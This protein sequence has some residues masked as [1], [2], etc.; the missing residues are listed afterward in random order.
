[1][2]ISMGKTKV[3]LHY[4][5]A[6][7]GM[8]A[9]IIHLPKEKL[10]ASADMYEQNKITNGRWIAASNHL[11][12]RKILNKLVAFK[13]KYAITAHSESLDPKHLITASNFF[14]DLYDAVAP[15]AIKATLG[16]LGAVIKL[17]D[18][19]PKKIK[20]DKYKKLKNYDHLPAHVDRMIFAIFHG[21]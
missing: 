18:T 20:L 9:S 13:P 14:N 10:V 3:D 16:D 6:G 5:G 12:I 1:M 4:Y 21:G 11:G 2:T 17:L 19:L 15:Q 7:D 8:A